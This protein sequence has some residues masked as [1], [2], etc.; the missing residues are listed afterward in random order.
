MSV[1]WSTWVPTFSPST[2]PG[3]NRPGR[4]C[5]GQ[6]DVR[7]LRPS[8]GS[9]PAESPDHRRTFRGLRK[10]R[11]WTPLDCFYFFGYAVATYTAVPFILPGLRFVRSVSGSWRG[12]ALEGVRVQFPA[13]AHVHCR[14]Q[15]FLFDAGGLLRRNDYVAEIAGAFMRGSHGWD[16]FVGCGGLRFPARRTVV[17]RLGRL[18][19]PFPTVLS[20][21]FEG[22]DVKLG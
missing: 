10:W 11:R 9:E 14:T 6:G 8:C 12:E 3:P 2:N 17:P 16:D 7:L 15:N 20:A 5:R 1:P 22:F 18:L 19:L 4:W 13:G 21:T